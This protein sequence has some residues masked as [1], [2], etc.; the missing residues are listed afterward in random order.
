[1]SATSRRSKPIPTDGHPRVAS[2]SP[3]SSRRSGTRRYSIL[4]PSTPQRALDIRR[5]GLNS[6]CRPQLAHGNEPRSMMCGGSP[7]TSR[8]R[9]SRGS[10][11]GSAFPPGSSLL[12]SASLPGARRH[13]KMRLLLVNTAATY[14]RSATPYSVGQLG[15]RHHN[16]ISNAFDL[17]T[18]GSYPK[19]IGAVF[20]ARFPGQDSEHLRHSNPT[21][22][23]SAK[24]AGGESATK[25]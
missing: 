16:P 8:L 5:P 1:M 9:A 22:S 25:Q 19:F 18:V 10:N 23:A 21:V 15:A 24:L 11:P 4:T 20:R 7:A 6:S 2:R 17:K 3:E 14:S 13:P 12:L